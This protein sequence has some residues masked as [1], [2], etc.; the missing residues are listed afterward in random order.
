MLPVGETL[1]ALLKTT[2][3]AI[4]M[5]AVASEA[6][7]QQEVREKIVGDLRQ[8]CMTRLD[9]VLMQDFEIVTSEPIDRARFC[10]CAEERL[11]K[12]RGLDLIAS[13]SE[14]ERSATPKNAEYLHLSYFVG[15]LECYLPDAGKQAA[16]IGRN[17]VEL[18]ATFE[19][20]SKAIYSVYRRALK[21]S[22]EVKGRIEF[23]LTIESSGKVSDTKVLF[24]DL[25][26][27]AMEME[28]VEL[29]QGIDFG[30]KK[31]ARQVVQ[32]P[33]SFMPS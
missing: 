11:R 10:A 24:S 27:K 30:A 31:V 22:P 20:H 17:P 21:R 9:E 7:A 23:E 16:A 14:K 33:L 12:D 18:K 26:D 5:S 13:K 6:A 29:L 8:V 1:R 25:G 2:A 15:G 3:L 4:A 28:L 32:F 19:R